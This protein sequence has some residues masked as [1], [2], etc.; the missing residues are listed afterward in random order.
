MMRQC[1]RQLP[2]ETEADARGVLSL[3]DAILGRFQDSTRRRTTAMRVR[4]HGDYHL[5]Q[6]L[7]TGRD[8]VVIDFEGQPARRLG[9][10][11][12]ERSPLRDVAGMIRSFYYAA[13]IALRGQASTVLRPEHLP[14]LEEWAH[15]WYLW[16]STT[17]LKS[18]LQFTADIRILPQSRENVRV[19]LDAYL[20]D[21]AMYEVNYELNNRPDRAWLPLQGNLP[22]LGAL[23]KPAGV[24]AEAAQKP[25]EMSKDA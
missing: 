8:F 16:V 25:D 21:K 2:D 5:G 6:L 3:E 12:I 11:R 1:L 24:A 4:C 15:T 7:Y 18:Y 9:E 22:T 14:L 17:F 10:R 13:Y 19:I 20:V 23:E